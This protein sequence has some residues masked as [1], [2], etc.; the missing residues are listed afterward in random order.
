MFIVQRVPA[1]VKN[2]AKRL[3]M[4]MP[5][6]HFIDT[7]LACHL[8]GLRTEAQLLTSQ[9]HGSVL[10]TLVY[11]E[12]YKQKS[13]A[14]ENVSMLHFRDNQKREVDIVLERSGGGIVGVEVKASASLKQ[15]DFRGLS[16]LADYAGTQFEQG[17]I[18]Y[19]GDRLLP[20]KV[21]ERV[22]HAV[23]MGVFV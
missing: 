9:F 7:G 2:S 16:A 23:P 19:S 3:V 10:E 12:L 20:F 22:F 8:L 1:Y 13:W 14:A 11:M 15:E 6:L 4:Q 21:G 18:F 5:K 17:V